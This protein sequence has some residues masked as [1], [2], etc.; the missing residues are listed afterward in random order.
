[1][2]ITPYLYYEDLEGVLK[3]L[4]KAFGFRL[5]G[6][7]VR[8]PNG[9]LTHAA[10]RLGGDLI[11]MG[12]PGPTYRNPKRLKQAT[13]CL[14]VDVDRLDQCFRRARSAGAKILEEP[15]DTSYGQRRFAVEDPEGHQWFFAQDQTKPGNR[16]RSRGRSRSTSS[17]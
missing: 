5:A 4:S 8:K 12:W 11:M 17:S 3:F 14:Y 13:Q 10:M 6:R 7:P 1:M 9:R 2:A 15:M 16:P